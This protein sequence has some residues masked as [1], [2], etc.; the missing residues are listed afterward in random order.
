MKKKEKKTSLVNWQGLRM[1]WTEQTEQ[2][3]R[4][5]NHDKHT[6]QDGFFESEPFR[7]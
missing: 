3:T 5:T 4:A 6:K 7:P 2:Y 1:S